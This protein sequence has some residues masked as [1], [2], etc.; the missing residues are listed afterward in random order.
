MNV[1]ANIILSH[2]W[3]PYNGQKKHVTVSFRVE[4]QIIYT[5]GK[6]RQLYDSAVWPL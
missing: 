3:Q 6:L 2:R 1:T 5:F 4:I